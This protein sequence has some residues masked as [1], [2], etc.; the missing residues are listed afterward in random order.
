MERTY[1]A[2]GLTNYRNIRQ[3]TRL[4]KEELQAIGDGWKGV[5]V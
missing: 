2:Y 1:Q 5:S 3:I 4:N